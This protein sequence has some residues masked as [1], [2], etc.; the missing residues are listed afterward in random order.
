MNALVSPENRLSTGAILSAGEMTNSKRSRIVL[1]AREDNNRNLLW[2][3]P[4]GKIR[5]AN[6]KK[7][8]LREIVEETGVNPESVDI[9]N[10]HNLIS[11]ERT[12]DRGGGIGLGIIF[13][14]EIKDKY[15]PAKNR[16]K[17]NDP[18]GDIFQAHIFTLSE[19]RNLLDNARDNIFRPEF[20]RLGILLWLYELYLSD[21]MLSN[22]F[23][24]FN[25]YIKDEQ[26]FDSVYCL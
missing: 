15:L 6:L 20:N 23:Q 13:F 10:K 1:V 18:D 24:S 11:Y 26:G 8:I 9:S 2:G 25:E 3:L 17:V 4:A 5:G 21:A 19:V 7:E 12:P 14:A 22:N 16:W